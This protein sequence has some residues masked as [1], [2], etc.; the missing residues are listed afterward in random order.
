MP[1]SREKF[2]FT[3]IDRE[4]HLKLFFS[5]QIRKRD[6]GGGIGSSKIYLNDSKYE[7]CRIGTEW[8]EK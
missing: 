7:L 4:T 1:F 6:T 5:S 8:G 2:T 3:L